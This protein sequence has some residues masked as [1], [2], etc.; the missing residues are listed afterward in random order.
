MIEASIQRAEQW[1]R[2]YLVDRDE[3]LAET[4]IRD[5]ERAGHGRSMLHWAS[6]RVGVIRH[7]GG[8]PRGTWWRLTPRE[9]DPETA[10]KLASRRASDRAY[11][12]RRRKNPEQRA[13]DLARYRARNRRQWAEGRHWT[14]RPENQ[15]KDYLNKSRYKRRKAIGAGAAKL[16]ERGWSF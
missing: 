10:E 5:A 4:A 11:Y 8:T 7:V 15:L 1:L 12:Q 14:Q 2:A 3:V 6:H 13:K 9:V 16:A